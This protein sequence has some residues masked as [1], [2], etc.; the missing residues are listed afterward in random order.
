MG[1]GKVDSRFNHKGLYPK[2]PKRRHEQRPTWAAGFQLNVSPG[3]NLRLRGG[4]ITGRTWA[5]R[6][7]LSP[8]LN[9]YTLVLTMR[10]D[11]LDTW[12][13]SLKLA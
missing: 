6:K 9:V 2:G 10:W 3:Q 7:K 12:Q 5:L 4:A 13:V 1:R 8:H 11:S